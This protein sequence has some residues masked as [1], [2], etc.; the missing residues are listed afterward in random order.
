MTAFGVALMR[1]VHT[2][3]DRPQ[4]IDD[5][6]GDRLAGEAERKAVLELALAV[7][8][9][10]TRAQIIGNSTPQTLLDTTLRANPAYGSMIVRTRYCE[11]ALEA[12]VA[13]GVSQYV[14][15]GAGM[16]SFALRRPTFATDLEI[17]E[18][19]H[20]LTQNLKRQ[21][22]RDL[23]ITTPIKLHFIA[24]DLRKEQVDTV[25]TGT[26]FDRTR[27]AFFAC[28]GVM[29]YLPREVNLAT[30]RAIANCAT[31]GSVLVFNYQD[32]RLQGTNARSVDAQAATALR[33][34]GEPWLSGF[35]PLRLSEDLRATGWSLREDLAGGEVSER[36]CR[37]QQHGLAP[38]PSFHIA[39]ADV[40][41]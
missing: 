10:A 12:A 19:D 20:P 21:R 29:V 18:I 40:Q 17:F 7:L 26:G 16:D 1:A 27:P 14:I 33:A 9:P 32:E 31:R 6:W 2:R 34:A 4:L 3:L 15:V 39:L 23:G 41:E 13:G 37:I 24:A 5:P 35:D 8:E 30:L 28:L 38:M 11:D 25:L 36:Y 22:L